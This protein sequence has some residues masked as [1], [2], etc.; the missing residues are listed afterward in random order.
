MKR[1][2]NEPP[3]RLRYASGC[4]LGLAIAFCLVDSPS[5]W[6]RLDINLWPGGR[7]PY[8]FADAADDDWWGDAAVLLTGA[9]LGLVRAEMD[10]WEEA[11][12]IQDPANPAQASR[13]IRFEECPGRCED[14]T[15]YVVI[16]RNS[17]RLIDGELRED[18]NMCG[19]RGPDHTDQPGRNPVAGGQTT[20][21]FGPGQDGNTI[22][23]EL[24]HCLGLWHEFGRPDRDFWLEES[25][26]ANGPAEW[27]A[28]F[29]S[30]GVAASEMPELGN[31]DYDSI[32]HYGSIKEKEGL[33]V[34]QWRDLLGN[35]FNRRGLDVAPISNANVCR[36]FPPDAGGFNEDRV[37]ARDKSRV[38][39]YYARQ[40]E[41]NWGFFE[42]LN[43][44]PGRYDYDGRPD[45]YLAAGVDAVGT[46]AVAFQSAGNH[47]VFVRGSDGRLYWKSFRRS[48]LP[49]EPQPVD[50]VSAWTSLG[51]CFTSDP[52][53]V[54]RGDGQIDVVAIYSTGRPV[55]T[56]YA[57]NAW[58]FWLYVT[59]G[60]PEGGLKQAP[61]GSYVGP[62]IASRTADSIDVF[63]VRGD[64]R[65][66]V[67]SLSGGRW[68]LWRT[69]GF[70]YIV[71]ARPA[72][73]AMSS[74]TVRL[75]I[76]E[77]DTHLFEPLVTFAWPAAPTFQLGGVRATT[78]Y[79]T[80]PALTARASGSSPYRVLIATSDN[81]IAHK[82]AG[83]GWKDIGGIP[84]SDSGVSAVA[85]GAYSA[86]IVMNGEYLTG[87]SRT[88]LDRQHSPGGVIQPGG[89]WL[90]EFR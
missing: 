73:L 59:D 28:A 23:H 67:T 42:S 40:A 27:E 84:K 78:A 16:R 47:D 33:C 13:Y 65:L 56:R 66:A 20:L 36:V 58:G 2:S 25:P 35:T 79:Q 10:N 1:Q 72:A 18:N 70:G 87:C 31:Y 24:G 74:S 61:D 22:R 76:N 14:E 69:I 82:F 19:W 9:E 48:W 81:R 51:C 3:R 41:P 38:L 54:S 53:A 64:G 90:R 60:V 75:A 29:K 12:T 4:M 71:T 11:M 5:A 39:Q 63:V 85:T 80:P 88:C 26:E 7:V 68:E 30:P 44:R 83:G 89:I 50:V 6:T 62:A 46:P 55:R 86:L 32:M 21:H 15:N 77:G 8:R 34:L 17:T 52:S 37:S 43:T 57:N 49:F 45:P